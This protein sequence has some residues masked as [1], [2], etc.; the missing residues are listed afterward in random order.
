MIY[1]FKEKILFFNFRYHPDPNAK[2]KP[3]RNFKR[4]D[5]EKEQ[6]EEWNYQAWLRNL[7]GR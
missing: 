7:E 4:Q 5:R 3:K 6:E 1:F 2:R